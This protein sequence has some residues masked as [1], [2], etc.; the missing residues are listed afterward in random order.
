M[1]NVPVTI[2]IKSNSFSNV[3][4]HFDPLKSRGVDSLLIK[5]V[6]VSRIL[7]TLLCLISATSFS[8][9]HLEGRSLTNISLNIRIKF[10]AKKSGCPHKALRN[11]FFFNKSWAD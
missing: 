11:R 3:L 5:V 8:R 6:C 7:G 9:H 4:T 2:G 1:P 10:Y